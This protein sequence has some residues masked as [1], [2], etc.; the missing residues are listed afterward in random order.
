VR[1]PADVLWYNK[2]VDS[3]LEAMP[4][5][6]GRLGAMVF[7][8]TDVERVQLNEE[9]LWAGLPID[10]HNPGG[11][12]HLPEIRRLLLADQ[13]P[14]ALASCDKYLLAHPQGIRPYQPVG[15]LFIDFGDRREAED[16]RRALDLSDGIVR[17]D[18]R[19]GDAHFTHE[20][21]AS[22]PDDVL[23]MRIS[24]DKPN[25]VNASVRLS[26]VQDAET[27][28]AGPDRIALRGQI[29]DAPDPYT[30]PGGAHM[31]FEAL[32]RALPKRGE[33]RAKCGQ[34]HMQDADSVVL[35]ITSAT[36]YDLQTLTFDRSKDPSDICRTIMDRASA[37]PWESLESRHTD[38]HRAIFDRVS[39]DLGDSPNLGLPVDERLKLVRYGATDNQ[40]V[41][42]YF[43]FG[44]YLLMSCSRRPGVL[45]ANLQGIWNE[46]MTPEWNCDYHLN[47]NLQ[48]NY[49]PAENCNLA[50][51]A[52]PLI[53]FIDALRVTGRV[54][55]RSSYGARGWVLHDVTDPFGRS[56]ASGE[57]GLTPFPMGGA[58][59]VLPLWEHYEFTDDRSYLKNRLYP[60]MKESAEFVLD[61]LTED[62]SGRLV[63]A[64]SYS[65]ENWFIL[66]DGSMQRTTWGPTIDSEI[67]YAL[68]TRCIEAAR[69]LGADHEFSVRLQD[70]IDHLPPLQ[71]SKNG[72]IQEWIDD[73]EEQDPGHRHMSH[74]LA[75]YPADQITQQTPELLSAARKT[76]DRR[77]KYAQ[78]GQAF[79][80]SAAWKMN[81]FARLKDGEAAWK[82]VQDLLERCTNPA[83]LDIVL[84]S[85]WVFQIDGNLGG[86]A[87]IAEMLVQSHEGTI[88]SR[89][90]DLLPALPS[91]WP[92]GRV[93][94]LRARGNFEV[95]IEW[96]D[97]RAREIRIKSG[98]GKAC[99]LHYESISGSSVRT[100]A[101]EAIG[102]ISLSS[103]VIEF[104]TQVGQ[105]YSVT[106]VLGQSQR[107]EVRKE[108]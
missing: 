79:G 1:N 87:G 99:R 54:T 46:E 58:W 38:E 92:T 74:L 77:L 47:I 81:L 102:C 75:L 88:G 90:I 35:L 23:A 76:I 61:F 28:S 5:G 25:M 17:I 60:I 73:H 51:T 49:W 82:Q 45:P 84:S 97:M 14:E 40:L 27:V 85:H 68:F 96:E 107:L 37:V 33:L 83:L 91:A 31:R 15:D 65:P 22:A 66:P 9:S 93:S 42:Q 24:C 100:A 94:G 30:G 105:T 39:I 89:V 59:T 86:T 7:G 19:I 8:R 56:S 36:D 2:A 20:I 13:Y 69:I 29:I 26:R 4:V 101:G 67:I 78:D 80:W 34:L 50:E 57:V 43:Q 103:D 6:N 106:P 52:D 12:E 71:I 44:R 108:S 32:V 72:T 41:A 104:P 3:W 21:F 64:P 55:A 62:P 63:T 95:S 48:M 11:P 53:D 18:Y 10:D 98:S 70:A 16:Y